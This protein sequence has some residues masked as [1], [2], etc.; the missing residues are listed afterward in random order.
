M[1]EEIKQIPNEKKALRNFAITFGIALFIVGSFWF[2]QKNEV[3][4]VLYSLGALF[5]LCGA[6]FPLLVRRIHFLLASLL[7]IA[8]SCITVIALIAIYYMIFT[9]V[10]VIAAICGKRFLDESIDN[11]RESYWIDR[12]QSQSEKENFERQY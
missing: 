6:F 11:N 12:S 5:I 4:K 8:S 1:L 3:Y 7:I 9:P 10:R 2:Y